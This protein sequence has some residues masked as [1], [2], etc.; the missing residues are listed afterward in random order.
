MYEPV[1][2]LA[3]SEPDSPSVLHVAYST[4]SSPQ[5]LFSLSFRFQ[6]LLTK[7]SDPSFYQQVV[8]ATLTDS[9]GELRQSLYLD[10]THALAQLWQCALMA[11]YFPLPPL[12]SFM[13]FTS[14]FPA[15]HEW[16]SPGES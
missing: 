11:M 16:P 12:S 7:T 6:A 3:N 14:S 13:R 5:V 9:L 4:K 8:V 1:L 10:S 15:E 2:I